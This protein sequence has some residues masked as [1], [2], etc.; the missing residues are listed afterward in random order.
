MLWLSFASDPIDRA[1]PSA[2]AAPPAARP[3]AHDVVHEHEQEEGVKEEVNAVFLSLLPWGVSILFH[4]GLV[5][6]AI[7]VVWSTNIRL[8]EEEA[9]I[10]VAR[11]S[12]TPGTP[13][14]SKMTKKPTRNVK[15]Q[16]IQPKKQTQPNKL[17]NK[18][19][20]RTALIGAS[21]GSFAKA[22]PFSIAGP[23]GARSS[24]YGT[25]GGNARRIVYLIDASGSL[26]DSLPFVINELKRSIAELSDK[27]AFTVIFF[28][29]EDVIEVPPRGLKRADGE[30]KRLVMEWIGIERG[31]VTPKGRS[32]PVRAVK[33]ALSYNPQLMF[34][35]SDNITGQ[36][37][38]EVYQ[39]RLL[40]EIEK[41]NR[42]H[43]KI[44]TIQFLYPDPLAG[45]GL[46]PTLQMI[47][48]RTGGIYKFVDGRELGIQ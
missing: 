15:R 39:Q 36:G 26:I 12:S 18:V 37:Q 42:A 6:L 29:G 48:E 3:G 2:P 13:R 20:A 25:P 1:R 17:S 14:L 44:N 32:N 47:S 23:S 22:S 28:Q 46:K 45:V 10:P 7:F 38:Y 4:V 11:L 31:N 35:L 30:T 41:T 8:A 33:V 9:I 40:S 5:F 24:F 21:G 34:L 19:K 16:R 43:A 27:Q